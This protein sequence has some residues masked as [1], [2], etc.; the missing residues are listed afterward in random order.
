MIGK[1]RKGYTL[2]EDLMCLV[3]SICVWYL[4][5]LVWGWPA[6]LM[7]L[8][9]ATLIIYLAGPKP[10]RKNEEPPIEDLEKE[11]GRYNK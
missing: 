11:R 4:L 8:L 6:F 9:Y 10:T 5:I 2:F 1:K 7:F 3:V